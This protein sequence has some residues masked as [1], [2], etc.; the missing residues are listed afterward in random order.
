MS[1]K[2]E[3]I[4]SVLYRDATLLIGPSK[5]DWVTSKEEMGEERPSLTDLNWIPMEYVYLMANHPRKEFHAYDKHV[6]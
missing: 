5:E 3:T 1:K 4:R 6:R 2:H